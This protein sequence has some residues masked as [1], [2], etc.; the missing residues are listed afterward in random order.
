MSSNSPLS[1]SCWEVPARPSSELLAALK[2]GPF[3]GKS[4]AEL[5][6]LIDDAH[7]ALRELADHLV[8]NLVENVFDGR[9]EAGGKGA[10]A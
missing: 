5:D 7:A 9:H 1:T 8:M 10:P 6:G 2:T 3:N 4:G